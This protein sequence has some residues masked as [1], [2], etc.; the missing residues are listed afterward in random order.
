MPR[1]G[2]GVPGGGVP[3]A[4][5]CGGTEEPPGGV[6]G[7][8]LSPGSANRAPAVEIG[9]HYRLVGRTGQAGAGF[10]MTLLSAFPAE[11]PYA[12]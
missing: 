4:M 2:G 9:T 3:M 1:D 8:G 6:V 10:L 12:G 7:G 11:I 5:G